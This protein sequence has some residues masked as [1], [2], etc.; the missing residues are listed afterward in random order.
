MIRDPRVTRPAT[1]LYFPLALMSA[2]LGYVFVLQLVCLVIVAALMTI[3]AQP[4]EGDEE[5]ITEFHQVRIANHPR[6]S[7]RAR[8]FPG[9]RARP[10]E[11]ADVERV[12]GLVTEELAKYGEP[13]LRQIP[14]RR[15]VLCT[16]LTAGGRRF[17]GLT[18]SGS[19]VILLDVG[20]N[21]AWPAAIYRHSFH[22]EMSHVL[23]DALGRVSGREARWSRLNPSGFAYGGE[24]VVKA[25]EVLGENPAA[26]PEL[27]G[28]LSYYA[29]VGAREDRAEIFAAMMIDPAGLRAIVEDDPILRSKCRLLLLELAGWCPGLAAILGVW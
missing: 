4:Y 16:D 11:A 26:R 17:G 19:G 3:P 12:V 10:A 18:L 22:H 5:I 15:V 6:P 7:D 8:P 27:P 13:V 28:F 23:D 20:H 1:A 14:I 21:Q 29:M 9:I 25:L 2:L 24:E